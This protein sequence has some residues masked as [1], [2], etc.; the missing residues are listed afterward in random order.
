MNPG[1]KSEIKT[2]EINALML[3]AAFEAAKITTSF[4]RK[5]IAVENKLLQGFD[6]VTEADTQAEAAIRTVIN[7]YFPNHGISGE[8]MIDQQSDSPFNWV[9]DPIDGTRAFITGLPVW[10]TL[11][12]LTYKGT[13]IAGLMS[14]PHIGE[15]F[16]AIQG[17]TAELQRGETQ[18]PLRTSQITQLDD[19]RMFTT[20]PRIFLSAETGAAYDRL[21][22]EVK[23][24][25]YGLDCY[26]YA[27]LATGH[28]ELVVEEGL[29][30]VDIAAMI[31]LI[32]EAGGI[33]TTWSGK[34]AA[35]GGQVIAAAN[36]EI[37]EAALAY[38]QPLATD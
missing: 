10:G 28:G 11:I 13:P 33:V 34:S 23:L 5:G 6:P 4:F 19:A 2:S 12:A 26:G 31:P 21:E 27:M 35:N 37:Y 14:Q 8:E 16:I 38:L 25:R 3:E 24:A 32:E 20:S 1:W 17:E 22:A 18:T 7:A 9:I 30:N 29:K 15:N 36:K